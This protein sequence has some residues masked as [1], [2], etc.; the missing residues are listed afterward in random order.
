MVAALA[1]SATSRSTTNALPPCA[2]IISAVPSAA[3]VLI[4]A[5]QTDTSAAASARQYARPM[6]WPPPVTT[7]TFPAN[8]ALLMA[9]RLHIDGTPQATLLV[10]D[11]HKYKIYVYITTEM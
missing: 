7:A 11:P 6:P 5:T 3:V 8:P 4:S 9:P 1:G 10:N 2:R